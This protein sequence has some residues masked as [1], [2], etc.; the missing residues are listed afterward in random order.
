[1][2]TVIN[3]NILGEKYFWSIYPKITDRKL[4]LINN[5]WDSFLISLRENAPVLYLNVD[6]VKNIFP[7]WV[8]LL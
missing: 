4:F 8:A 7:K 2:S 3:L 6:R 5:C 1:M